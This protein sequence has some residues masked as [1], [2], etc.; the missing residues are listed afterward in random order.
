MFE[1]SDT[2]L[3]WCE[4]RLLSQRGL[5]E[6]SVQAIAQA[7]YEP[8]AGLSPVEL[9]VIAPLLCRRTYRQGDTMVQLGA[10]AGE[11]F[12][13]VRGSASVWVELS[14]GAKKR[15]A[16]FSPGMAFGE[17]ALLDRA[18]RS[19]VVRADTDV[20]CDLLPVQ[21]FEKLEGTHPRIKIVLLRN[22]ALGLSHKL[23][24]A[25]REISVFD[26]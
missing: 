25:N 9:D 20:E 11:L 14:S 21:E 12:I 6:G 8:L 23:R 7:H 19:A 1:D 16:A 2:A 24:K 15:L 3:E 10:P 13:L 26:Y 17:M 4:N 22:L 18:P 5:G